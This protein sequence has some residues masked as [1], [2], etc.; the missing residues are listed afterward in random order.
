MNSLSIENARAE[1]QSANGLAYPN[2]RLFFAGSAL[3]NIGTWFQILAQ[4]LLILKITGNGASLGLALSLQTLPFLICGPFIGPLLDRVDVR[5]L[6]VVISVIACAEALTLGLLTATH[7]VSVTAIYLLSLVLGLA[8]MFQLPATQTMV[9]ELVPREAIPSAVSYASV[10]QTIGRLAG[11]A[12][13]ALVYAWLGAAACYLINASSY[14]VVVLAVLL[15]RPA[16]LYPRVR[17]ARSRRQFASAMSYVWRSPAHRAQLVTNTVIGVFTFNFQL[18]FSSFNQLVLHAG[19]IGLGAA[20]STNACFAVLTGIYLACRR[21]RPSQATYIAGCF[22][23]GVSLCLLSGAPDFAL[24]IALMAL[25]GMAVMFYTSVS[26]TWLQ[27]NTP[28]E[29]IGSVMTL[30]TYGAQGTT[31]LGALIMGWV[32][33]AAS[34][35]VGICVGGVVAILGGSVLLLVRRRAAGQAVPPGD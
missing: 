23:L 17:Q 33:D 5:R 32:I 29:R 28:R 21:L 22:F 30:S 35:R 18:F 6:F 1:E 27:L 19:A 12:A 10:Q 26:Q 4:A 3:S 31:A 13:A 11:P 34:A 15:I 16:R 25:F 2:F 8:Q 14:A 7:H 20:E 9:A 24:Y